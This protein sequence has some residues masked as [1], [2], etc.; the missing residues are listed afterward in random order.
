MTKKEVL[1]L[2]SRISR[3]ITPDEICRQLVK[4]AHRSSVYSYLR[5][6]H[7]QGLL[8]RHEIGGRIVYSISDRGIERLE[9]FETQKE[10][11]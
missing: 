5:R 2:F 6:L 4:S 9:Y 10:E 8:N 1:Q 11:S 7:R 3:P